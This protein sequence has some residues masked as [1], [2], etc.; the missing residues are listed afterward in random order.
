MAQIS[1]G[2]SVFAVCDGVGSLPRS[3]EAA[4]FVAEGIPRAYE[5]HGE[6]DPAIAQVN[7]ELIDH[8]A[9]VSPDESTMSTTFVGVALT[10]K[11]PGEADGWRADLAWTDD[12]VIWSLTPQGWSLVTRSG[13]TPAFDGTPH[14]VRG[15]PAGTPRFWMRTIEDI[16]LPLFVMSDG[17]GEPMEMNLEVRDT[18]AQWWGTPPDIYSFA[19]QVGFGRKGFFDDRTVIGIWPDRLETS[20]ISSPAGDDHDRRAP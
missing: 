20:P 6:W 10:P 4:A 3:G 19:A 1:N 18:L 12:S 15:L 11:A 17:V 2:R 8:I 14:G 13:D 16:N 5:Q 7:A 9:R